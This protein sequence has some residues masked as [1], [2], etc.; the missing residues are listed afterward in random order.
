MKESASTLRTSAGISERKENRS[1]NILKALKEPRSAFGKNGENTGIDSKSLVENQARLEILENMK[2]NVSIK[3]YNTITHG[4]DLAAMKKITHSFANSELLNLPTVNMILVNE[5]YN[6]VCLAATSNAILGLVN[7]FTSAIVYDIEYYDFWDENKGLWL[8]VSVFNTLTTFL[9][10]FSI[11]WRK[12]SELDLQKSEHYYSELDTII[13]SKKIYSLILEILIN[14][15]HPLWFLH[16]YSVEMY[17]EVIEKYYT[18]SINSLLCVLVLPRLYHVFRLVLLK[19]KYN[20]ARAHRVCK[21]NGVL[22]DRF[23]VLKC[24]MNAYPFKVVILMMIVAIFSGGFCLR[25]FER[26]LTPPGAKTGFFDLG[27]AMWCIIITMTTVGF[28]DLTPTS[29]LGRIVGTLACIWG[30][31]VVA[32]MVVGVTKF[33]ILDSG[34][35]KSFII[36]LRLKFKDLF[37]IKAC[38]VLKNGLKFRVIMKK[39]KAEDK[40]YGLQQSSYK[41]SIVEFQ[42]ARIQGKYLYNL[43]TPERKIEDRI[44]VVSELADKNIE[45][46][47][48]TYEK[49]LEIFKVVKEKTS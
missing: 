17:N 23:W 37:K 26:P 48:K 11:F 10:I 43:N 25:I 30:V 33:M 39:F 6:I 32:L 1:E 34:Q 35:N 29:A 36:H 49:L 27:N 4:Y 8:Q 14:L 16:K 46:T 24:L 12:L 41:R 3:H 22:A 18:Q 19:S 45:R 5:R 42:K 47:I 31:F 2:E 38:E 7:V 44:N 13:S 40:V 15:P 20:S 9:L 21:M 28:G